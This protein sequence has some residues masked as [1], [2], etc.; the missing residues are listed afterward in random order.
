MSTQLAD[1]QEPDELGEYHVCGDTGQL[2]IRGELCRVPVKYIGDRCKD[3]VDPKHVIKR[4][5]QALFLKVLAASGVVQVACR[6]SGVARET[7]YKWMR[8]D[9]SYPGRVVDAMDDAADILEEEAIRRA[10]EG[11]DKPIY[12]NG[13]VVDIVKEYSDNLLMFTLKAR[14]PEKFRERYETKI[15]SDDNLQVAFYIPN[16]NRENRILPDGNNI[17][18]VPPPDE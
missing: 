3:H 13:K 6:K 12:H 14:R 1:W 7:H 18:T 5:R 8:N 10:Y 16:N 17:K 15:T 2:N 4:Q 9:P 11:V